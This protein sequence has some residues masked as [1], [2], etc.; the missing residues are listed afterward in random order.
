MHSQFIQYATGLSEGTIGRGLKSYTPSIRTI[1]I[2]HPTGSYPVAFVD[3]PG[4]DDTY[5]LEAEILA[6]IAGCFD[7]RSAY[8]VERPL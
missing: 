8:Y 1:E 2:P 6:M 3:T 4:F 7:K 5:T